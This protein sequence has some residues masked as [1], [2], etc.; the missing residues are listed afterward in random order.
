M[1][2]MRATSAASSGRETPVGR[3]DQPDDAVGQAGFELAAS[4][5]AAAAAGGA[6]AL[7]VG[8]DGVA[9][10]AAS[11]P[12]VVLARELLDRARNKREDRE[13]RQWHEQLGS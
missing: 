13:R 2:S 12:A 8:A 1:T 10:L 5:A 6:A 7:G 4:W 11:G 9:A 3:H